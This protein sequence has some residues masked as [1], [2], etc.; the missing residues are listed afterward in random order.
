MLGNSISDW[1]TVS[2]TRHC[3][4]VICT[5]V[6]CV[7]KTRLPL[8]IS[9]YAYWNNCSF[10]GL[11]DAKTGNLVFHQGLPCGDRG[12]STEPSFIAFPG[13][14]AE[15]WIGKE[16]QSDT[17][18][19]SDKECW[20]FSPFFP[21]SFFVSLSQSFFLF[22]FF[23]SLLSSLCSFFHK[24]RGILRFPV[25]F[26]DACSSWS[27]WKCWTWA[28]EARPRSPMG[29]RTQILQSSAAASQDTHYREVGFRS[30]VGTTMQAFQYGMW[31]YQ[32]VS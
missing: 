7:T 16:V 32:L 19:C 12:S 28:P 14:L 8:T 27:W 13:S 9:V 23:L 31:K 17:N 2:L 20:H 24:E 26:S 18:Q 15:S 4:L 25:P 5:L 29:G 3:Q 21:F 10:S 22:F 11:D 1:M 30:R 6:P